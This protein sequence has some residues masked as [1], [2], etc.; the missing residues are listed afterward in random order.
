MSTALAFYPFVGSAASKAGHG[1]SGSA[2]LVKLNKNS[3]QSRPEET[4]R[5][6][7]CFDGARRAGVIPT[8]VPDSPVTIVVDCEGVSRVSDK[9][10]LIVSVIPVT[11]RDVGNERSLNRLLEESVAWL[12][13]ETEKT[14]SEGFGIDISGARGL[15]R[16]GLL[17]D[18]VGDDF[19]AAFDL[20]SV[21]S[22]HM[23]SLGLPGLERPSDMLMGVLSAGGDLA[24]LEGM[25]FPM[26]TDIPNPSS[27]YMDGGDNGPWDEVIAAGAGALAGGIAG[28]VVGGIDNSTDGSLPDRYGNIDNGGGV[29]GGDGTAGDSALGALIGAA[30]GALVGL[31]VEWIFDDDDAAGDDPAPPPPAQEDNSSTTPS[32]ETSTNTGGEGGRCNSDSDCGVNLK[33]SGHSCTGGDD[34]AYADEGGDSGD[35]ENGDCA[36][37]MQG[38]DCGSNEPSG[39]ELA[40]MFKEFKQTYGQLGLKYGPKFVQSSQPGPDG[41]DDSDDR[42]PKE[43]PQGTF[44]GGKILDHYIR[45]PEDNPDCANQD[46]NHGEGGT[47]NIQDVRCQYVNGDEVCDFDHPGSG[48]PDG[49]GGGGGEGPGGPSAN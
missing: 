35:S 7:A 44:S 17:V 30:I 45:C 8:E 5:R 48:A 10:K 33:C 28:G 41:G 29:T 39:A 18:L 15:G 37:D 31:L 38:E 27:F 34:S 24:S 26:P 1:T 13:E 32:E 9:T 6:R 23:A 19:F 14:L 46:K 3:K 36:A 25:F 20:S 11:A 16:L 21:M 12:R 43:K 4:K 42:G 47:V 40:A 2:I 49:A 22:G